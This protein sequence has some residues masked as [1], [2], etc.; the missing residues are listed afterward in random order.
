MLTLN[1]K[2]NVLYNYFPLHNIRKNWCTGLKSLVLS[3]LC[4]KRADW[5]RFLTYLLE[6]G[7]YLEVFGL[8]DCANIG[9]ELTFKVIVACPVLAC[10]EYA[11]K[12]VRTEEEEDQETKSD[13]RHLIQQLSDKNQNT[14]MIPFPQPQVMLPC[15]ST[16]CTFYLTCITSDPKQATLHRSYWMAVLRLC[17]GIRTLSLTSFIFTRQEMVNSFCHD[18]LPNCCRALSSLT[19]FDCK[20]LYNEVL[21]CLRAYCTSSLSSL[22]IKSDYALKEDGIKQWLI[23]MKSIKEFTIRHHIDIPCRL[24]SFLC[25]DLPPVLHHN[26]EDIID[27]EATATVIGAIEEGDV[28]IV[29]EFSKQLSSLAVYNF[30][31]A[32]SSLSPYLSMKKYEMLFYSFVNLTSLTI[33]DYYTLLS[34]NS[35][36]HPQILTFLF[37]GRSAATATTSTTAIAITHKEQ[38]DG[39]A[40]RN[41][42]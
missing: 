33:S 23:Q 37:N 34:K 14:T 29:S 38:E 24:S 28:V 18:I 21:Q 42:S 16:L 13:I 11:P 27:D 10:I 5:R 4:D 19:I 36:S 32:T 26:E 1:S 25:S 2:Y 15:S 12:I 17:P 40:E 30:A 9:L 35:L 31:L 39:E 22:H 3:D 6:R 41:A 7:T 8:H 20:F